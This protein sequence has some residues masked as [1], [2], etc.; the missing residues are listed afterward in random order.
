MHMAARTHTHTR[1]D[2]Q[3]PCE[4]A[5]KVLPL[6]MWQT[7]DTSS[8][9]MVQGLPREGWG[10][11]EL[12]SNQHRPGNSNVGKTLRQRQSLTASEQNKTSQNTKT[13]RTH[14]M[15]ELNFREGKWTKIYQV[16]AVWHVMKNLTTVT[17]KSSRE[18]WNRSR[19]SI[20]TVSLPHS[21]KCLAFICIWAWRMS[22]RVHVFVCVCVCVDVCAWVCAWACACVWAEVRVFVCLRFCV[23]V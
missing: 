17:I 5:A 14:E 1:T 12:G 11:R 8:C 13:N 4:I 21:R 7:Q 19:Q 15:H 23:G 20:H 18:T 16:Y 3:T 2:R 10:R 9:C 6:F 22:A